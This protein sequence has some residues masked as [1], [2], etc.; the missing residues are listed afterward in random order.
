MTARRGGRANARSPDNPLS[1]APARATAGSLWRACELMRAL[2]CPSAPGSSF[3]R[4]VDGTVDRAGASDHGG[5]LVPAPVRLH[6]RGR[7]ASLLRQCERA[8]VDGP[9]REVAQ[10]VHPDVAPARG[11][12]PGA[13]NNRTGQ[14]AGDAS[15]V[16]A[17]RWAGA[18]AGCRVGRAKTVITAKWS[19]PNISEGQQIR[20]RSA[21][22]R[23][24][25][26][27]SG[28][29]GR[30]P[31][32]QRVATGGSSIVAWRAGGRQPASACR[33]CADSCRDE[34]PPSSGRPRRHQLGRGEVPFGK[35]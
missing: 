25:R 26:A 4:V 13:M 23:R 11:R 18:R 24:E 15:Q 1:R 33:S 7:A 20:Q 21:R 9:D 6:G 16:G 31:A 34:S 27:V 3:H 5:G 14:P 30:T 12:S 28:C 22:R 8:V 35:Q 17:P 10:P 19:E 32:V 29:R 2:P